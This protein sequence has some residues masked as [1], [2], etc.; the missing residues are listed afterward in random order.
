MS[1]LLSLFPVARPPVPYIAGKGVLR[2]A[3]SRCCFDRVEIHEAIAPVQYYV[4]HIAEYDCELRYL[5]QNIIGARK[6]EL[7]GFGQLFRTFPEL[8]LQYKC[9]PKRKSSP[10]TRSGGDDLDGKRV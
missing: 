3:A 8:Q 2:G 7:V 1:L 4:V 10:R 5:F 6:E 9:L